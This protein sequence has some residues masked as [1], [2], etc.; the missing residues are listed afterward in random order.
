MLYSTITDIGSFGDVNLDDA[1]CLW[2]DPAMCSGLEYPEL[3]TEI[4]DAPG[5]DGVLVFPPFLGGQPVVLGGILIVPSGD[6]FAGVETL[7]AAIA[8]ALEAMRAAPANIV[9]TGGGGGTLSVWTN[10][11]L[12]QT[13]DNGNHR[14]QFGLIG[15]DVT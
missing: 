4:E 13:W 11:R 7:I 5:E 10:G 15:G 14:V 6:Y 2:L 9:W 12:A 8:S 1:P 3:R